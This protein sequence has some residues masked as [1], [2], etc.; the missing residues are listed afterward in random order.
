MPARAFTMDDAVMYG[1]L[2][3]TDAETRL[4]LGA[5]EQIGLDD[6]PPRGV[7]ARDVRERTLILRNVGSFVVLFHPRSSAAPVHFVDIRK[8]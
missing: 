7:P 6:A 2:A 5:M 1:L 8:G 4:L 3:C